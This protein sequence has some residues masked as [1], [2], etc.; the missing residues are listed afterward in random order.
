MTLRRSLLRGPRA[1]ALAG[2]VAAGVVAA[3]VVA[4][5]DDSTSGGA[6][7][8]V[9]ASNP[10]ALTDVAVAN[11]DSAT[12]Q[13]TARFVHLA[14]NL[15]DVDFC[16]RSATAEAFVGPILA[17]GGVGPADAGGSNA[18]DAGSDAM[19][20]AD[21]ADAND[22][23]DF[24]EAGA[25]DGGVEAGGGAT[26]GGAS[27]ALA[28]R[29]MTNYITFPGS[30]T[31]QVAVVAGGATTC[32]APLATLVVTLD[33]AKLATVALAG[34]YSPT[35]DGGT[36][37]LTMLRFIDDPQSVATSARVRIVHAA[38]GTP[39]KSAPGALTVSAKGTESL[40]IAAHV[41]PG[42]AAA[43]DTSPPTDM[44]GY[45]LITPIPPSTALVV[46]PAAGADGGAV[47]Q[48]TS[49]FTDLGL[50]A[51]SLHTGFIV[52][53]DAQDFAVVWCRDESTV[54][55][56]VDCRTITQPSGDQ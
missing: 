25:D 22:A 55:K 41:D 15:G 34:V 7:S 21:A 42:Q 49:A 50:D 28:P 13:A 38:L 29:T 44:L 32:A 12:P 40:V 30:G 52:S 24:S 1:V 3:A 16:V 43:A 5:G 11:A 54:G 9:D 6:Q 37:S 46:G 36:A 33:P 53:D 4:C 19:G 27:T 18:N 26:D 2:A 47:K 31:F 39:N 35:D 23:N 8:T 56:R 20:A 14:S 17:G 48:W 10:S 51:T 45:A